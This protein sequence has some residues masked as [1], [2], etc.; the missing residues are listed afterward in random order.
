MRARASSLE[1]KANSLKEKAT[2]L[3]ESARSTRAPVNERRYF[4]PART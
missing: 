2:A 1:E 4:S 3:E